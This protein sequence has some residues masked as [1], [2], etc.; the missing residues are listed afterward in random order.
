VQTLWL[1]PNAL[2]VGGESVARDADGR[3]VFIGGALPGERVLV[4][5]VEEKATFARGV[6]VEV[7]QPSGQRRVPPCPH[8]ADGCGGCDWQHIDPLAQ[9]DL[10]VDLVADA[11]RRMGG[12]DDPIVASGPTLASHR[13]RTSLRCTVVAGLAGFRRRRSHEAL[14]VED[15]LVA[16]PLLAELVID[17]RFGEASEVVLRA[18]AR[19]GERLAAVSPTARGVHLPDDVVVVGEDELR[20]GKR[21][22]YH[23]EVAGRRWRISASSFFQSRPD[24]ADALAALVATDVAELA[25][26]ASRMVDLCCGVG[27][28]AGVLADSS[29]RR[30]DDREVEMLAVERH[31]PA[32]IDARHNLAG[33]PVR[34]IRSSLDQWRPSPATV[35][36]ADPPRSGL[37]RGGVG[38]VAATGAQLCVLVSCDPASLGRDAGLLARRGFRHVRSTMVD[39][40]PHTSHVEVVSAFTSDHHERSKT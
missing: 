10:K 14:V 1:E 19:T 38:A 23:E 15:C 8:V 36:V 40:F 2:A 4:E 16:H 28:F 24:G 21:A 31:R 20:A 6:A 33:Q 35:A 22:W 37:G 25:P 9:G 11:L 34:V 17:G 13:H 3:V 27:L 30:S 12:V 29:G 18:G 7:H 5:L 32:V 39:L 26:E